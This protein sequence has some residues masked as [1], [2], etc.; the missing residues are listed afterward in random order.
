[1]ESAVPAVIQWI[2]HIL[3]GPIH[4]SLTNYGRV[5]EKRPCRILYVC[6]TL[7]ALYIGCIRGM[8]CR[9]LACGGLLLHKWM[10]E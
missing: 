2:V 6:E 5:L 9:I 8:T 10:E 4:K 7:N 1:M 3:H